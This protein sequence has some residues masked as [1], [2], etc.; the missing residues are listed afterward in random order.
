MEDPV[1]AGESVSEVKTAQ[2]ELSGALA[3]RFM[4]QKKLA[5]QP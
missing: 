1:A 5:D 3:R 4:L 2:A